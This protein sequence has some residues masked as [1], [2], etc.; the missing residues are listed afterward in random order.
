[1]PL[2][3]RDSDAKDVTE[4]MARDFKRKNARPPGRP[5]K[6][7]LAAEHI[8]DHWPDGIYP[9]HKE[10]ARVL[11]KEHNLKISETSVRRAKEIVGS[12][13]AFTPK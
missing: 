10:V 7:D 13:V 3:I 5:R 11:L 1:M 2:C 4:A 8:S 6:V 12:A 9:S